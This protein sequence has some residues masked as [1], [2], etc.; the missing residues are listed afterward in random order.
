MDRIDEETKETKDKLEEQEEDN[1]FTPVVGD[2]S[3][4]ENGESLQ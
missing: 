3:T 2:E 4:C 1:Y